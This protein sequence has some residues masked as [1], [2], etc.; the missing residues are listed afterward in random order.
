MKRILIF[1]HLLLATILVVAQQDTTAF[2]R[3]LIALNGISD[4]QI[5]QSR[6]FKEKYVMKIRQNVD[7][8]NSEKGTFG[9]RIFVCL[10]D[11]NAPTV[12]VTEGYSASYG[13]SPAYDIELGRLFNA[14]IVLCE[15]RYF[16]Q[17]VPDPC[18][19]DYMTVGNSLRD[20][21]NVRMTI[22]QVLLKMVA[23]KYS[24]PKRQEQQRSVL[25]YSKLNRKC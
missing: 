20:L 21:H 24:L 16:D 25:L 2:M 1:I 23:T 4:V 13:L 6:S 7:G 17:S 22:G 15:Y 12:I 9:Q 10:R 18:N 14:N 5:L 3:Q 8:D 19:W 11:V